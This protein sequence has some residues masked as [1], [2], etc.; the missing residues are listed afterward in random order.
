MKNITKKTALTAV[1]A[2]AAVLSL[3]SCTQTTVVLPNASPT[4]TPAATAAPT[5]AATPTAFPTNS[6][7]PATTTAPTAVPTAAP[8]PTPVSTPTPAPTANPNP[9]VT[10]SG[11]IFA[12]FSQPMT[13]ATINTDTFTVFAGGFQIF[14]SVSYNGTV[15][16][17]SPQA[18]LPLN[19]TFTAT[20]TTGV[21]NTVGT[22]LQTNTVWT[23]STGAQ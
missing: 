2:S 1:V 21:K 23:F 20:L 3:F 5:A 11:R 6:P 9:V 14:G 19:T 15:A 18:P 7:A 10:G 16:Q 22:P 17:F 12:T 4:P 13:A 8:T